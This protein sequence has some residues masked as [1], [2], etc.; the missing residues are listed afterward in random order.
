MLSWIVFWM[1]PDNG[2][3]RLTVGITCILTI[4]FLLGYVNAMLPKVWALSWLASFA[5]FFP[6]EGPW[7]LS[8]REVV[9]RLGSL[10]TVQHSEGF[11]FF[12]STN[13][14]IHLLKSFI[15]RSTKS[16]VRA[17]AGWIVK[18]FH[19]FYFK[20]TFNCS[21]LTRRWQKLQLTDFVG[22]ILMS[23]WLNELKTSHAQHM[24]P[25]RNIRINHYKSSAF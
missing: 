21:L 22:P 16:R 7:R 9:R 14:S 19:Y 10:F 5:C 2:G 11:A 24:C 20:G 17:N 12:V 1:S 3:D 13:F 18:G 25:I 4:V 23:W 15:S 6:Y 8:G